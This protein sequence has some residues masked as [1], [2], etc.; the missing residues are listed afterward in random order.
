VNIFHTISD[1]LKAIGIS[2][3]LVVDDFFIYQIE[4]HFQNEPFEMQPYKH[5]FFE[6]SYGH[7]HD[8][9]ILIGDEYFNPIERSLSFTSPHNLSSWRV[10]GLMEDSLGY[11]ILFKPSIFDRH[12][13]KIDLYQQ[14]QFFTISTSP[15]LSLTE[16]EAEIFVNLM[17]ATHEEYHS[18][19]PINRSIINAY[20]TIILEKARDLY[21]K[22]STKMIFENRAA[23][24]AFQFENLLTEKTSYQLHLSDYAEML[25]ISTNYL[26]E[27]VKKATGKSAKSIS[28]ESLTLRAKALLTQDQETI[29]VV[30]Y[31]LGF[32]DTSN[33]VKFFKKR[34]GS[35]PAQFRKTVLL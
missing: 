21:S 9:D 23:E 6:I 10:N 2:R 31:K 33:F 25:N 32:S 35:T 3:P 8:V 11:M 28:Q 19:G 22:S 15:A 18:E 7:G 29:A 13:H 34:I 26:S 16:R 14:F 20:L 5:D 27:S 30:A 1:Y 17:A 24:I 4:D 12:Y